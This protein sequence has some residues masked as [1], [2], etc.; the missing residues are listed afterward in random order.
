MSLVIQQ[1]IPLRHK[2]WFQTGGC[3]QYYTEPTTSQEFKDALLYA[4]KNS[5]MVTMLGQGANVLIS[6]AGVNG[7]IIH[8]QLKHITIFHVDDTNSL[9]TAGAGI[10]IEELIIY[11][12][13]NNIS[14]LE[15]FSGIPGSIGGA[16]YINL[17]Y[18]QFLFS[19]F[20]VSATII[21]RLT[22]EL[23]TVDNAW[24]NFG[25]NQSTLMNHEYYVVD[26]TFTL[27]RITDL[28]VAYARGRSVEIIRH[29]KARYPYKNTCGSFFRN[30]HDNEVTLESNGKKVIWVAYYLDKIGIKGAL[31]VG[32]ASVS[33][34]HAN[35]I[36]TN[37]TTTS[38]DVVELAR[39]MQQMVYD[40]YGI[41]PQ[42]ECL[43]LGFKEY[44]LIKN[45]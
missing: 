40:A 42:S 10:T 16:T 14:G 6:D 12:L 26:V 9:V 23:V 8:P 15:E 37:D 20:I 18:F 39:T 29:R 13:D 11:C 32:G 36:V 41:L 33:H 2:N 27:K 28:E 25:Y 34:Q 35:M 38:S 4:H 17:H 3:A 45:S 43:M 22:G 7:L 1:N 19:N 24:F 21:H 44:P 31:S 30:F 5:L